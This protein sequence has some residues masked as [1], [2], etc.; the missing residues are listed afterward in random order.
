MDKEDIDTVQWG[1]ISHVA[2]KGQWIPNERGVM[3]CYLMMKLYHEQN[4]KKHKLRTR[5]L[6]VLFLLV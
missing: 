2:S 3:K 4:N 5:N 6:W 1:G